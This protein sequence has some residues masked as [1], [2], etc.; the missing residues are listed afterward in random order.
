VF[1]TESDM[2]WVHPSVRMGWVVKFKIF[3]DW[4]GLG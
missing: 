2:G 1:K 4:V 3:T